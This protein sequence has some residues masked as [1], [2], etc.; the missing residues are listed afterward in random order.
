MRPWRPVEV[1]TRSE[2]RAD[3]R[4]LR[5]RFLD[6]GEEGGAWRAV[7]AILTVQHVASVDPQAPAY[8]IFEVR[9]GEVRYR[10]RL[11]DPGWMWTGQRV[12][13]E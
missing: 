8:R 1:A 10:L 13:R 5:F 9:S 4:P 7:E 11:Q 3:Q 6:D 2:G 12:L